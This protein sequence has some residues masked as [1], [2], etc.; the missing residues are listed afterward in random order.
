M[1]EDLMIYLLKGSGILAIFAGLHWLLLRME[2]AFRMNRLFFLIGG[3]TS[4]LLPFIKITRTTSPAN[5]S[6][7]SADFDSLAVSEVVSHDVNWWQITFWIYIAGFSFFIIRLIYQLIKLLMFLHEVSGKKEG[8]FKL[9]HT[10][11]EVEPFSFFHYIVFY[12]DTYSEAEL[13]M[14]L[15]HERAHARQ[16]HSVDTLLMHLFTAVFWFHPL[17]R[18]YKKWCIQNLEYLA[19]ASALQAGNPKENYQKVL[20]KIATGDH[21]PVLSNPFYQSLIKKRIIMLNRK[22]NTTTALVKMSLIVPLLTIFM[23]LFNTR[24]TAQIGSTEDDLAVSVSDE[25]IFE[26]FIDATTTDAA[27]EQMVSK[28]K[29]QG[30]ELDFDNIE[31]N[32]EGLITSL[33]VSYEKQGQSGNYVLNNSEG[34]NSFT[35]LIGAGKSGFR[36]T[37]DDSSSTS[38]GNSGTVTI[39]EREN[40]SGESQNSPLYIVEGKEMPASYD[41]NTIDPEQIAEIHVLKGT[42]AIAQYGEKG[43]NGVILIDLKEE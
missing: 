14:I 7:P 19:D 22:S 20:L 31:R 30:A 9:V 32:N 24:T 38:V 42:S 36:T 17:V 28:A 29:E 3:L 40:R 27:L 23:F 8:P 5:P 39:V 6:I 10:E 33:K 1:I 4:L 26:I 16:R 34:I 41:A 13:K 12:P 25:D 18:I 21:G 37:N 43:R 11:R 2:N 15:D 35:L